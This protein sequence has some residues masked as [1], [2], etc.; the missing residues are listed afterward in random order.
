[1]PFVKNTKILLNGKLGSTK[2]AKL[3]SF[4]LKFSKKEKN[5]THVLYIG[6][7]RVNFPC[8]SDRKKSLIFLELKMLEKKYFIFL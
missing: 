8:V 6:I 4:N 1:M 2:N 5:F 7:R 3:F